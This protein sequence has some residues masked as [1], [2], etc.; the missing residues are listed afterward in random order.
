MLC[1]S[2]VFEFPLPEAVIAWTGSREGEEAPLGSK[3]AKIVAVCPHCLTFSAVRNL[4]PP[5][6]Q[7]NHTGSH[8]YPKLSV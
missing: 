4:A 7:K 5:K 3:D 8:S 1:Q 2:S 6:L